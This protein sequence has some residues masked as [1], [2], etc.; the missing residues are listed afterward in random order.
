MELVSVTVQ[1]PKESKEVFDLL[2]ELV[3]DIKAKKDYAAIAAENFPLLVKAIDG[4]GSIPEEAKS[5][6][7]FRL[8]GYGAGELASALLAK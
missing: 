8:A 5:E 3:K 4:V 6:A 7:I 2:I 1:L